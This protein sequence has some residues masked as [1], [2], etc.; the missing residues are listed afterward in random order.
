MRLKNRL[1]TSSESYGFF[2]FFCHGV[3]SN[4][5][6]YLIPVDANIPGENFLRGRAVL[7][8]A[9][10]DEL[11][12]AHNSLNVVVLD[13]CRDN[14]FAWGRSGNRGL[15]M[16]SRQ[17]AGS[18]I[19]YAT[20][21]GQQAAD[22]EGRNGLFT[23]QLL[24]NLGDTGL[25]VSEVFRRTG[26]DVS[27]ASG[28]RQIPAVYSQFF[29]TAYLGGSGEAVANRPSPRPGYLPGQGSAPKK[30]SGPD[31]LWTLGASVG[32]SFAD[33]WV[34]ATVR[35]TIAPF[36]YSFLEI[37][38]DAGF[39]SNAE[40]ATAY[41]SLYPFAHYA[42]FWP[43]AKAGVYIGVGGGVMIDTYTFPEGD[44]PRTVPAASVTAGV[45]ILDMIDV[46]YTLRTD[47]KSAGHKISVGYTYRFK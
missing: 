4:G 8:Q 3:Q 39:V 20:S 36:R 35:G 2:F 12:D 13:A 5:L 25:E 17:P 41:Y 30:M 26:A 46:S 23:G 28:N 38:F 6:N 21:A 44:V 40:G 7:M 43:F 22:G 27:A 31:R 15:A 24:N 34:I 37:G 18:I 33:P 47:F 11:N 10:L 16:V 9:V 45:N 29:G 1:S 32:T 14:P 42:F 19:V